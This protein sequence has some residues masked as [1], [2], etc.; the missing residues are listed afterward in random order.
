M[1][2]RPII[3]ILFLLAPFLVHGQDSILARMI[4]IGDAGEMD[5][6]QSTLIPDA[7]A[8]IIQGKTTVMFLGDNIYP[9][10][11]GLPGS[12]EE[13][14]TQQILQSQFKP[15][16]AA[17]A[18]VYFVPGNHDWDR[19]G[20]EGLAK[21]KAQWRYLRDQHDSLLKLLPRNGCPDPTVIPVSD[22]LIIVAWDSEWWL[23]PFDKKNSVA[24]CDCATP[25][26]VIASFREIL[27]KNRDKIIILAMHH[28]FYSYGVHG[29]HF[30][31]KDYIF[32]LRTIKQDLYIPLPVIGCI[33]PL[34]RK[35]FPN[36]EE[37]HN[38]IYKGMIQDVE[39]VF[40]G[41]PNLI[42]ASGHD[43]GMQLINHPKDRLLQIVSGGG[44]K[45]TTANKGKYSLFH[46][47]TQGYVV[48]D[49]LPQDRVN[50]VFYT[51]DSGTMQEAFAY[52]WKALPYR[53]REDSLYQAIRGDSTMARAHPA[54]NHM[55][56]FGR[57]WFGKNYRKAW[58]QPVKLPVIRISQLHGGLMPEKLGGGFQTTSLRLKDDHDREYVL[59]TI[60]KSPEKVLPAPFR[61]TFMR[62]LIDDATSAQHP[63]SAL[64]VPPVA[65]ALGV[66]HATPVIGVVAPDKNLG[67]YQQLF[68][69]KVTLLEQR[70][71]LGNSD[72]TAKTLRKLQ[73]DNDNS[74]DAINLL[75]ARMIDLY[76]GDWDRHGDQW[77][78]YDEKKGKEKYYIAIPRDRDMAL[79]L[80]EGIIP[81]LAKRFFLM[82]RVVGFRKN[83]LPGSKYYFYKSRFLSPY[84]ASQLSYQQWMK[85]ARTFKAKVTDSV[86]EEALKRLPG[87]IYRNEHQWLST[88]LKSRRDQMPE[89]VDKFYRFINR[90]VDIR[91]SDKN[92]LVRITGVK[93][94]NALKVVVRK[95]SKHGKPEDTLMSKIYPASLT[96]EIRL[97]VSGGD[98]S[99]V[100]NNQSSTVRLRIIGGKGHKA[101]NIIHSRN[102]V[103][104]Y[105]REKET[106]YGEIS[107]L[108]KHISSDSANTAFVQTDLYNTAI[109]LVTGS[110]NADDGLSLGVGMQ[111]KQR[112]GFRKTPYSA[113]QQI[114]FSHSFS[115]DAFNIK[116]KSEWMEAIGK[117]DIT[118]NGQVKAPNNTQNFFGRGNETPFYKTGDYKRYYRTRFNLFTLETALR[119]RGQ[120]GSSLSL[121]PTVQYYHL[122]KTENEGR[123]INQASMLHSYDSATVSKDKAHLG[124]NIHYVLDQ[125]NDPEFPTYG[126]YVDVQIKGFTGL[127]GYSKSFVQVIPELALYKSLNTR[128]TMVL[129]DRI[130]GG[131]SFGK[132]TFYQSLFLGGEG[133]LLGYR[134]Y[135]FAGQKS[136]YNNLEL[137]IAL[138]DFG[139]YIFK[140]QM[141]L[142]GFYDIGRVW[143]SGE[144]SRKWHQG[145]G[146]GLYFVPAYMAVFRL[147]AGYSPEGWYPYFSMGFRF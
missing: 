63:Y 11:M 80:T 34:Y 110:I 58:A 13:K 23:F 26:D 138:S 9:R 25:R 75:K 111:Y 31:W 106:Y 65:H 20:P 94:S 61:G 70:E 39:K 93:D 6:Q 143:Q 64:V 68:A 139:N 74:Y 53:K 59:R 114:M 48:A 123:F 121:G 72:N 27:Y 14:K 84:P 79:N 112:Q 128:Q 18:A 125:R 54:Y 44:S 30:N 55:S 141:G 1:K 142:A 51:Y 122:N 92:E 107:K 42:L 85:A 62:Q 119:W 43:H 135:R 24:D 126:A 130:G 10:G 4:F 96:R 15:M 90:I 3:I 104:L 36:P 49:L 83:L 35:I 108:K 47:A 115:T 100:L 91:T 12:K 140:G 60:E 116:F 118:V 147:Y 120:K 113:L 17:G 2:K 146:G 129:C 87:N 28:P 137:R 102:P 22:S 95:I 7:A 45:H 88:D 144:V 41:F 50:I 76:L 132:T 37:L 40:N 101:Y 46:A 134:K 82:P 56:G 32:P 78:F 86:I 19:M 97:Y 71:P 5:P 133:N 124:L 89:A 73:E 69:G 99:V 16:R 136:L 21:I 52:H 77:R 98:D 57:L 38:P 33:Y 109:P 29:G 117:A 66:P 145:V 105:D 131:I 81:T 67:Q 8:K 127:N 103:R